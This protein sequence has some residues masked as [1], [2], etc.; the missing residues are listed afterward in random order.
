M[1]APVSTPVADAAGWRTIDS[2][3]GLYEVSDAGEVRRANGQKIGM[4]GNHNGYLTVRL[5]S[6]RVAFLVH[7]LVALTFLERVPG[8]DV[9]NHLDHNRRN[10][11]V[12]NLEWCTQQM[13]L[14]HAAAAGRMQRDYWC[15]KRSPNARLSDQQVRE[16]RIMYSGGKLSWEKIGR[17]FGVSK[18]S[19]GRIVAGESYADV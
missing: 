4:W 16:I 1:N 8:Y 11:H 10:N 14:Q 5:S 17:A 7:R 2:H 15:G 18:R 13:N 6:P 19:V 3:V 12:P 9:V